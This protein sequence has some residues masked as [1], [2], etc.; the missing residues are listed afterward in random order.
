MVWFFWNSSAGGNFADSFSFYYGFLCPTNSNREQSA[1]VIR[2]RYEKE[3]VRP[4]SRCDC[5]ISNGVNDLGKRYALTKGSKSEDWWSAFQSNRPY[6]KFRKCNEEEANAGSDSVAEGCD[7]WK[8]Q[9]DFMQPHTMR[10]FTTTGWHEPARILEA[11]VDWRM[12][13]VRQVLYIVQQRSGRDQQDEM[14]FNNPT[15]SCY[16]CCSK[17]RR[18]VRY[19]YKPAIKLLEGQQWGMQ[20]QTRIQKSYHYEKF[21]LKVMYVCLYSFFLL[22]VQV[23]WCTW[24]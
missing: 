13:R 24:R 14:F 5:R 8:V 12:G 21:N 23:A 22:P 16:R 2:P 3:R 15:F 4:I 10:D 11:P 7:E 1:K 17:G 19:E 20:M 6:C 9:R 18:I